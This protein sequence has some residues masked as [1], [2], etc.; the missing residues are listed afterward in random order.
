MTKVLVCIVGCANLRTIRRGVLTAV[1]TDQRNGHLFIF[2][3]ELIV[4]HSHATHY[5]RNTV[6]RSSCFGN[7][8]LL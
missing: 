7:G 4:S 3:S 6:L 8:P 1:M 5:D 2:M